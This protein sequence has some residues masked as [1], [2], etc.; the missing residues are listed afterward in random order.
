MERALY[1]S[2][3]RNIGLNNDERI[4]LNNSLEK[5]KMGGL[6]IL[7]GANNS[8]KSNVLDA[9]RC[10]DKKKINERDL[11][12]LSFDQDKR[13]PSI[14][15]CCKNNDEVFTYRISYDKQNEIYY[16]TNN[17]I[18]FKKHSSKLVVFLEKLKDSSYVRHGN[19]IIVESIN[20]LIMEVN[21]D[22]LTNEEIC[23]KIKDIFAKLKNQTE[24]LYKYFSTI[25]NDVDDQIKYIDIFHAVCPSTLFTMNNIYKGKYGYDFMPKIVDYNETIIK[26]SHI[27]QRYSDIRNSTFFIN[28]FNKLEL[29]IDEINNVY[30]TF[31]KQNNN[32][33]FVTYEKKLNKKL[34]KISEDFN[35]LYY[36]SEDKYKF[37]IR[38]DREYVN[39][40]IFKGSHDLSLDYQ[41]TG[42]KWFFNL[43][44]N[45]LI[46]NKLNSGDIIL[47]DEPATNL[48]VM[49][50]VEL[51]NFLKNFAVKN[52]I[53]IVLA[54]HSPFLIDLDNLD[55]LRII[56]NNDNISYIH[57]DY[58]TVNI[59]DPDSLK[60]IKYSLTV[61]NH[62]IL[63]PDKNV[64][65][66]EGI[67]DYN[68]LLTFKRLL[69]IDDDIVFLP[70]NG[71]GNPK[72]SDF[73]TKQIAISKELL[74]IRKN[75]AVLLVDNDKPGIEI[76]KLNQKDSALTVHSLDEVDPNFKTIED[77]F[78]KE[79][80]AENGFVDENGVYHKYSGLSSILKN[81]SKIEDFS[82]TTLHN[83][84]KLFEL[85]K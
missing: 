26:N 29:S 13:S 12:N 51:R 1:L 43:Y 14:S 72:A 85:F 2:K 17:I 20:K 63:D 68:Y 47:M 53:T 34:E 44:F 52:D 8:G 6:V 66:V 83:F 19:S 56:T 45:L 31:L 59:D 30:N 16:N 71:L 25:D 82:E 80:L 46:K 9:L 23:K 4:V 35:K 49:G 62:V 70:I 24:E 21:N 41:S 3:F 7:V 27:T 76:K 67:T 73:K 40:N 61:N 10:Y 81:Y 79:D 28:L 36:N 64:V 65:F 48:H 11:T 60:P 5:G 37:E 22:S 75:N 69:D 38:L 84:R 39:F 18:D 78:D 50:Q 57:N 15:L 33:V 54:T 77:L 32:G 74:K 42:F 55:E 58:T